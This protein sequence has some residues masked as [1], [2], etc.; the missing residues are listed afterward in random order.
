MRRR[1]RMT[2]PL[3]VLGI[4]W[5]LHGCAV[6]PLVHRGGIM[7][8]T[9]ADVNADD[10]TVSE[11]LAAFNRAEAVLQAGNLDDLMALYSAQYRYHGMEK[12]DLKNIRGELLP[13]HREF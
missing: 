5:V 8:D 9:W 13:H 6:P 10:K 3:A 2:I 7:V 4:L 12:E 1:D 11:I